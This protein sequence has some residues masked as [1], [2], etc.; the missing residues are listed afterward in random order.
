MGVVDCVSTIVGGTT[1]AAGEGGAGGV[2]E[3]GIGG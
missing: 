3:T 2:S 1:G